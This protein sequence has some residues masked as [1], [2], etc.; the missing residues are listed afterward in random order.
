MSELKA[1]VLPDQEVLKKLLISVND[2]PKLIAGLYPLI[3]NRMAGRSL[4]GYGVVHALVRSIDDFV[5]DN[6]LAPEIIELLQ[7]EI[8]KYI[9]TI[10]SNDEVRENAF[11]L[12]D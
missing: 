11:Q 10:I 6:D 1:I 4:N 12:I 9:S 2:N 3:L 7:K 8:P 5:R